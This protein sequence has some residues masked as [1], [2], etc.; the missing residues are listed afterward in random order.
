MGRGIERGESHLIPETQRAVGLYKEV[1]DEAIRRNLKVWNY[2]SYTKL[3]ALAAF[4][5][6]NV[7]D[8]LDRYEM[9]AEEAARQD[10][11]TRIHHTDGYID[12]AFAGLILSKKKSAK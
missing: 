9:A 2:N 11:A 6:G 1:L 8:T 7:S 3:A 5:D 4:N 10:I 12:I